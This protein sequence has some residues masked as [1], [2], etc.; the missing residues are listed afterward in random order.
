VNGSLLTLEHSDPDARVLVVTNMWPS[1]EKPSYGIFVKRQVDSLI[2]LGLRCDVLFVHGY[3]SRLAYPLAAL[4]LLA[5]NWLRR[6]RYVLVHGH[7]GEIAAAAR[8]YS[9]APMLGTYHGSDILGMPRADGTMPFEQRLRRWLLQQHT[10]LLD[11]T[12]TQSH[13]MEDALPPGVRARNA[14]VPNGV[15]RRVFR[16][17]DR[18]AARRQLGWD[19]RERIVLFAA[20]PAVECK[21]YGL[22][23]EA[24]DLISEGLGDVRLYVATDVLPDDMPIVMNAAD[25]LLLTSSVEGSST[26][27]KEALMCNLPVVATPAGDAREILEGVDPSWICEGT[28]ESIA[29]ALIDCLRIPRRCNGRDALARLGHDRVARRILALYTRIEPSAVDGR[30]PSPRRHPLRSSLVSVEHSDPEARVLIITNMWPHAENPAYGIFIKRQV[31][32]LIASGLRCDVLFIHGY[33][34]A[35]AYA[36]AALRLLAANRQGPGYALVHG[37]GGE[38][39]LPLRFYTRAPVLVSY[40]GDD[41]LGT[42]R[43]DGTVSLPHRARRSLLR[44]HARLLSATLTKSK[45]MEATLPGRLRGRNAVIPSGCDPELFAPMPREE[46][47]ARM[48]WDPDQRI[49]LFAADPRVDRKRHWLA[50]AAC[51]RAREALPDIRLHVAVG[52]SPTEMPVLMSAAD[53]LLL[54]SSIEGSPNVVKEALMCNLPVVVTD[55]GDVRELLAGVEPSWVCPDTAERLA[56]A[57]I[58]CL[59]QPR[60]SNGREAATRVALGA[61]NERIIALYASL[62]PQAVSGAETIESVTARV[63]RR[64]F[65]SM[66][67]S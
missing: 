63:E 14:V 45:Q 8:F 61:I 35:L 24:C 37:H 42:P 26:V 13:E 39:A 41:L 3:R 11:A 57:L 60:R 49:V 48:G 21:R 9:R 65:E 17:I 59:A 31:E 58:E 43:A 28:P 22:A 4:K 15:D 12:L 30:P 5:W 54:T 7:G 36:L 34:S 20:D 67:S 32:S 16:P 10:R 51:D 55:V 47:R 19:E 25:C 29:S 64:S 62:A 23:K 27:V 53:C 66:P 40:V 18:N 56:G 46:A 6:R 2:D 44:Q 1:E 50:S 33:R 38:T 52:V